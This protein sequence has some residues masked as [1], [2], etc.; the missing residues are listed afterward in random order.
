MKKIVI[1]FITSLFLFSAIALTVPGIKP[2]GFAYQKEYI[3]VAASNKPKPEQIKA[4]AQYQQLNPDINDGKWEN[5]ALT[6]KEKEE[7]LAAHNKYRAELKLPFLVWDESLSQS[8]QNWA[9]RTRNA[10]TLTHSPRGGENLWAGTRGAF[11]ATNMVDSW[12][13]EKSL[14]AGGVFPEVAKES[15]GWFTVGHYTQI[16]WRNTQRIGCGIATDATRDYFVCHYD[17]VGNVIGQSVAFVINERYDTI[18]KADFISF[19]H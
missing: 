8:A 19:Y 4:A 17:P 14:Y 7:I 1:G 10:H 18:S 2:S 5:R 9:Y 16:V 6:P 11:T 13:S 15:Q 3:A 12:G